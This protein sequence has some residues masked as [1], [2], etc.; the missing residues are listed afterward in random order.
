M[1]Q[2][3]GQE[4]EVPEEVLRC[5]DFVECDEG[6]GLCKEGCWEVMFCEREGQENGGEEELR[7]E[8]EA[9]EVE[10]E[11]PSPG[12]GG[13]VEEGV[14]RGEVMAVVE[15]RDVVEECVLEEGLAVD[16]VHEQVEGGEGGEGGE[17]EV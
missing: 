7:E 2:V 10:R 1:R 8:G 5:A 17:E 16:R 15:A 4:D 12:G 6:E 13:E 11:A 14:V 3:D 9:G